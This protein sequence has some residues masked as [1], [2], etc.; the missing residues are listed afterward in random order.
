MYEAF[1]HISEGIVYG[2]VR[3][4]KKD[5]ILIEAGGERKYY[6]LE[7]VITGISEGDYVRLFVKEGKAFFIEKLS[8]DDYENF[9]K[10]IE[11]LSK[12]K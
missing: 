8:R 9:R 11:E 1:S 6:D 4:V 5:K 10:I 2:V 12:I 3:E 7:T